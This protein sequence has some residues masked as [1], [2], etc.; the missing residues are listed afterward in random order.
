MA[1][2]QK[3]QNKKRDGGPNGVTYLGGVVNYQGE[4][5]TYEAN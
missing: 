3:K 5:V 1:Q 2:Y 4:P